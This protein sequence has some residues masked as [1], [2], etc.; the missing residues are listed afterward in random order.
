MIV[1]RCRGREPLVDS[2]D[3]WV[4]GRFDGE[5][6]A[7]RLGPREGDVFW[8]VL[9]DQGGLAC[10][11]ADKMAGEVNFGHDTSVGNTALSDRRA[12]RRQVGVEVLR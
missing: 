12:G 1:E 8:Q 10:V 7:P 6:Q 4:V 9:L 11:A 3:E 2:P 5:V